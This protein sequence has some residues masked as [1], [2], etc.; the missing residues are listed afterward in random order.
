MLA[1]IIRRNPLVDDEL[2]D[3][4]LISNRGWDLFG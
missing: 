1:D 2:Q 4:V 3:N